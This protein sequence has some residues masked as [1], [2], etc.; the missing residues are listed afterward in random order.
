[1]NIK[2]IIANNV[3]VDYNKE[4][5]NKALQPLHLSATN[6]MKAEYELPESYLEKTLIKMP[7]GNLVMSQTFQKRDL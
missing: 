6:L 2:P 7:A 5:L 1:M 4:N 3:E